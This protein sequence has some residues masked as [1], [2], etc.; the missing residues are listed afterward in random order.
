M[1]QIYLSLLFFPKMNYKIN[2]DT[3]GIAT[4]IACAIHCALLPVL[5]TSLSI[6]G[7][8]IVHNLWF[9]WSMI[10]LAF[11]I[12]S[13]SLYHGY[14]KHHKSYKPILI[15]TSGF[16]FLVLKQFLPD[17]EFWLLAVAVLLIISA[18]YYNYRLCQQRK[19][20]V[21]HHEL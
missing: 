2:W 5:M 19:C 6:F 1:L 17:Y 14:V 20:A 21:P 12:G 9:E 10:G 11:V 16:L 4:S 3:L 8:N 18:H 13:Y 15:F 7:I